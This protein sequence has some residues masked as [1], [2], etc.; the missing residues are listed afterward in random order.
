MTN[1]HVN[2][3]E[4]KV[5]DARPE[6]M[7]H[8]HDPTK[9][10]QKTSTAAAA[11]R[12]QHR[13]NNNNNNNNSNAVVSM[14]HRN[15]SMEHRNF[16]ATSMDALIMCSVLFWFMILPSVLRMGFVSLECF[17]VPNEHGKRTQYMLI[18]LEEPCWEKKHLI[19]A[20]I[21]VPLVLFHILVVPLVILLTLRKAGETNRQSDPIIMFRW[22]L[23][24]SGYR[25]N[26]YWWEFVVLV[27]KVLLIL[28]STFAS[29]DQLQ[30][31]LSLAVLII[32]LHLHDTNR[33]FGHGDDN[34]PQ[35]TLGV[36]IGSIDSIMIG[37]TEQAE[38]NRLSKNESER[39]LHLYE[40][41]SLLW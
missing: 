5:V 35:P 13:N 2:Y 39:A 16:R 3:L 25:N 4:E 17:E 27:R 12:P 18:D 6:S 37:E 30:L 22:G 34:A 41:G 29:T 19:M 14:A 7:E 38:R 36:T 40:M 1:K 11:K 33:P 10:G 15:K 32:S 28:I 26:R 21:A 9:E 31:H 23:L 20:F 24:H 8:N